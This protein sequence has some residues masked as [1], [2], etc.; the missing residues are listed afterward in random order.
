MS[1]CF[2]EGHGI[3]LKIILLLS[4]FTFIC[5]VPVNLIAVV[6]WSLCSKRGLPCTFEKI[7][8]AYDSVDG[9]MAKTYLFLLFLYFVPAYMACSWLR[10]R[11]LKKKP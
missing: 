11:K 7:D 5:W 2:K 4:L 3:V 8:H 9:M 10:E 1:T 6:E